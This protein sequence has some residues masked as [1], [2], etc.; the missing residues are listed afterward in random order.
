MRR[1][2][3]SRTATLR[4]A[5]CTSTKKGTA[6]PPLQGETLAEKNARLEARSEEILAESRKKLLEDT[7]RRADLGA[8]RQVLHEKNIT[9]HPPPA[10]FYTQADAFRFP[11]LAATSLAG[12]EVTLGAGAAGGLFADKWT[13]L[14]C[15]NSSFAMTMVDEWLLGV[16]DR[17]ASPL[18]QARWLSLVEGV[19]LSWLQRPLLA[20]MRGSVPAARHDRFLCRFDRDATDLRKSLQMTNRYLGYVCLVDTKG[21][22]RWHVHGNEVPSEEDLTTL[23]SQIPSE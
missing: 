5:L 12:E 13:L 2:N 21:L 8:L 9:E 6:V 10:A 7:K 11:E 20:S 16:E 3:S 1:I 18:L 17:A 4:R 14:G 19:A 15:A 23:A 22:V